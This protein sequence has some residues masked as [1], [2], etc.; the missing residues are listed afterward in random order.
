[1]FKALSLNSAI[2]LLELH[3]KDMSAKAYKDVCTRMSSLQQVTENNL[4]T[5]TNMECYVVRETDTL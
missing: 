2:S 5:L 4:L 1:M 3:F